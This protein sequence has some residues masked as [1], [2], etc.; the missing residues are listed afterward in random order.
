LPVDSLFAGDGAGSGAGASGCRAGGAAGTGGAPARDDLYAAL[1]G[2]SWF[3]WLFMFAFEPLDMVDRPSR[4]RLARTGR[5][6]RLCDGH[7]ESDLAT[8]V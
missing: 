8:L 6:R 5:M 3:A 4:A 1:F 7:H 2:F